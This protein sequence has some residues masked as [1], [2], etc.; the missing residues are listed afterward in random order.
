[1][2][3]IVRQKWLAFNSR[4]EAV[5]YCLYPDIKNLITTGVGNLSDPVKN[6]LSLPLRL[7]NG[8]IAPADVIEKE[9]HIVKNAGINKAMP[10]TA[11]KITVLRLTFA[12]V[13]KMVDKT[14][15]ENHKVLLGRFPSLETWPADAQMALHSVAWAAGPNFLFP[16]CEAALR[17]NPPDFETAAIECKLR[18]E[19]NPGV[20]QRNKDN[21]AFFEAAAA[22]LKEGLDPDVLHAKVNLEPRIGAIPP[23]GKWPESGPSGGETAGAFAAVVLSFLAL[24]GLRKRR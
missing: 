20:I 22:V 11:Y 21:R 6:A 9:W 4:H 12:D 17:A 7:P 8:Q 10:G 1:M 23:P 14:L 13:E 2:R 18:E 15:T 3:A 5:V 19:G 16:K 24:L